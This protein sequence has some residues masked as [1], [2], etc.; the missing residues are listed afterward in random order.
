MFGRA[1]WLLTARRPFRTFRWKQFV[2]QGGRFVRMHG[3]VVVVAF[4]TLPFAPALADPLPGGTF[5]PYVAASPGPAYEAV[6]TGRLNADATVDVAATATVDVAATAPGQLYVF[7]GNGAGGLGSPTVY[8][9]VGYTARSVA[10]GDING[11]GRDDLAVTT[12]SQVELFTQTAT[13]T[14]TNAGALTVE[15]EKVRI[16]DVTSDGRADVV[17]VGWDR[18]AVSVYPQATSGTLGPQ[19]NYNVPLSGYNDLEVADVN[20][21]GRNDIVAMSA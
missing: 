10:A 16:A 13:G 5:E 19:T 8:P 20:G 21:D 14:L 1:E 9:L 4:V 3:A 7:P 11:D 12:R 17:V 2:W 6:T 15:A 18:D